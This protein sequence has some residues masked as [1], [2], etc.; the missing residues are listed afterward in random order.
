MSISAFFKAPVTDYLQ[1]LDNCLDRELDLLVIAVWA[2]LG[3]WL[4]VPVHELLHAYGCLWSGGEVTRLEI[5][6]WYGA[7]LL[8][9]WFPFV[10]SGSDYAGQLTGFDTKGSDVIYLVTVLL[11]FTLTLLIG[12]PLLRWSAVAANPKA[13]RAA[14]GLSLAPAYAPFISLIGDYYETGSILASRLAAS[15]VDG[16]EVERWRSDD[17]VLLTEQ[18]FFSGEAY[19]SLDVSIVVSASLLGL[20]L[21][22]A[23]YALG[24]QLGKAMFVRSDTAQD[25]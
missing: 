6:P 18:L 19:D 2:A 14:L 17:L 10:V 20:I 11:P 3:W 15:I 1:A 21:A 25:A 5:S 16:L 8:A 22:L 9:K 24:H 4:Y 7:D 13:A 12:V 23:T